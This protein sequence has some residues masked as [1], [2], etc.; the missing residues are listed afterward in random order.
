[1]YN[2]GY[3]VMLIG[4][5]KGTLELVKDIYKRCGNEAIFGAFEEFMKAPER[6]VD[7]VFRGIST[8]NLL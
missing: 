7:A 1:M 3:G 8:V 2:R 5:G 6:A 4:E